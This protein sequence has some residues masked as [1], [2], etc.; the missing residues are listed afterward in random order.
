MKVV[1]SFNKA[2]LEGE[3]WEREIRAASDAKCNFI[4]FNHGRYIDPSRYWD[5]VKLDQ[6]YQR[7]DS[8]LMRLYEVLGGL[9]KQTQADALFVTNCPPYHPEFLRK[10]GIYKAL[11]S[12]DDPAATYMRTIPYVHAYD[13]VFYCAPGYSRDLDLGKKLEYAGARRAEW[14][15]LGVF[16]FEFEPERSTTEL[17]DARRDIDIVYVGGCFRQKL[18][19]L[20]VVRNAFGSRFRMHGMFSMKCNLYFNLRHGYGGWVRSVSLQ[21]R[22]A[23]YQRARVG[24]NIHWNEHGL[25][26]QRLYHLPANGV[27]QIS[28]CPGD[29]GRVFE[30]G[31]EVDSYARPEELLEKI[32]Y[33]LDH[34]AE[35]RA[36]A[37]AGHE[38]VMREYRF[39]NIL[40]RAADRMAAATAEE[41]DIPASESRG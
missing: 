22:V 37:A 29:L 26:N 7:R 5:S 20:A 9:L 30:V 38:R 10:L 32:R 21:Q 34:E 41:K 3:L 33:Y 2:D 28:D 16:D 24:F 4:P 35:R 39:A 14:L 18:T 6:I 17:L 23:L 13:H 11:Y 15:P 12:T 25:G 36:I 8:E 27:M 1:L 31:R 40:R 19:L